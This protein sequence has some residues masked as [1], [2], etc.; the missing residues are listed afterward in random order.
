MH[1]VGRRRG[2]GGRLLFFFFFWWLVISAAGK[3]KDLWITRQPRRDETRGEYEEEEGGEERARRGVGEGGTRKTRKR[4]VRACVTKREYDDDFC[5]SNPP[6]PSPPCPPHKVVR[7]M[8]S[9]ESP[10][11][12][13]HLTSF[14]TWKLCPFLLSHLNLFLF[15]KIIFF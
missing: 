9:L 4:A 10:K 11:S 15:F 12:L 8:Q 2:R 14:F 7:K 6:P 1:K 3:G 13:P 5:F